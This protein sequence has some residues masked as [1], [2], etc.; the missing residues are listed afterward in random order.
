MG[1]RRRN[2]RRNYLRTCE[3]QNLIQT[4]P[5]LNR[6]HKKNPTALH[7]VPHSCHQLFSL[8]PFQLPTNA[9]T[10]HTSTAT[11]NFPPP[12]KNTNDSPS[13]KNIAVQAKKNYENKWNITLPRIPSPHMNAQKEVFTQIIIASPSIAH[14][15]WAFALFHPCWGSNCYVAQ[16]PLNEGAGGLGN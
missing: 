13:L 15:R 3:G 7:Q 8:N 1:K 2:E 11:K 14:P 4:V 6:R 9:T 5:R 12:Q 16:R 10:L